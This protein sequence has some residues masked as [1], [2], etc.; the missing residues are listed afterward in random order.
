[1]LVRY[2]SFDREVRVSARSVSDHRDG[3]IVR[4]MD[5]PR[6]ASIGHVGVHVRDLRASVPFYRDVLGLTV[7]DDDRE[8]GLVFMS[9]RPDVEHHELLLCEGRTAGSD[10]RWLQQVSWRCDSLDDVV[11]FHAR[12]LEQ[13]I[14]VQYTVTHGNAV[15][16]YFYDPDG[17]RCE[18][19]WATGLMAR[20]A[21]L[22][23]LDLTRPAE[24]LLA[25][26]QRLVD[27]HGIDG[28]IEPAPAG[29]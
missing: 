29:S 10:E 11:A 27:E 8:H 23:R 16:V 19:Y 5:E 3:R 9:S 6:I 28:Y 21:F 7:T 17:N 14:E 4:G 25:E 2:A 26:V 15:G 22:V 1:M 18:V 24:E 20:Q 13:G 12:F